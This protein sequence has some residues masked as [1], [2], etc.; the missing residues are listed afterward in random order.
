[1]FLVKTCSMIY[2]VHHQYTMMKIL[3]SCVTFK[4]KTL[5]YYGTYDISIDSYN[6]NDITDYNYTYILLGILGRLNTPNGNL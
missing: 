2:K 3:K 6:L 5:G 4:I 1:M